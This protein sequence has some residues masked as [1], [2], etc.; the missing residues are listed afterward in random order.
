MIAASTS[1]E[2]C[3]GTPG[4]LCLITIASGAITCR[5]L[6][7]S[8]RVSPLVT[9]DVD[10]EIFI[11]SADNRLAA[12]SKD[13]LVRVDGS[14]KRL[15]TVLPRSVGTFLMSRSDI[16][17]NESTVSRMVVISSTDSSRMPSRSFLLNAT[18][19]YLTR[20]CP[21]Q[22]MNR[23]RTRA[24]LRDLVCVDSPHSSS[25]PLLLFHQYN[26]L[27]LVILREHDFYY[28]RIRRLYIL[29]DVIRLY[30]QLAM[31]SIDQD[32]QLDPARAAEVD[33][34]IQSC[35]NRPACIKHIIYQDNSPVSY[36]VGNVGA[37][38]NRP[39]PDG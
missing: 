38:Y 21:R 22:Q 13:V 35:S 1:R 3:C 6:A 29:S 24:G 15:I 2:S 26:L 30:R 10:A 32:R 34:L 33:Q 39:R 20:Y 36:I 23:T 4:E 12:I 28:L 37:V 7:V 31:A 25:F 17:L 11:V 9:D 19:T 27:F 18:L 8:A 14:K 5:L 16:S